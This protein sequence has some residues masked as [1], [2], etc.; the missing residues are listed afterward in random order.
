MGHHHA[1]CAMADL[2]GEL[3]LN[4]AWIGTDPFAY[5]ALV[6]FREP[7]QLLHGMHEKNGV[8]WRLPIKLRTANET[9]KRYIID[10]GR[11]IGPLL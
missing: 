10:G 11:E 2:D 5:N 4:G 7:V 8:S 3:L 6:G 9:P 1:Q